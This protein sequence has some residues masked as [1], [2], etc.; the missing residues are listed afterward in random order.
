MAFKKVDD[1]IKQ[2][3]IGAES[4]T[5]FQALEL[6]NCIED[7]LYFMTTFMKVQH[8]TKGALDFKPYPFQL[9]IIKA[10]HENRFS[11]IL[12]GRQLGKTSCAA[13]FLLWK[14]MFTSDMTILITANKLSQA[15]E[16][17]DRIKYA[18]ENMPN[19]IRAGVK[20]YNKQT[21]EFD[22]GSK[23]VA[24]ATTTDAGRGLSVS[25]LYID[26]FSF[27]LP[28]KAKEFWTSIQPTLSTG[29][30]CIITS[31]PKTDE[32]QFA[33][34]WKGATDNVDE[35]GNERPGKLGKNNFF[36]V[37]APW[38]EHPDRDEEWAKTYRE[39]LGEARFAQEMECVTGDTL[40]NIKELNGNIIN[41]SLEEHKNR[42]KNENIR[43]IENLEGLQILTPTG[44]QSFAG[45]GIMGQHEIYEVEFS[46]GKTI[47]CS[48]KHRFVDKF[49][50]EIKTLDLV[51]DDEIKS[52]NGLVTVISVNK[53]S[54]IQDTY[55]PIE[56]G[57]GHVYFSDGIASKNCSF[58]TD[59][60]TLINPLTLVRLSGIQPVYYTGTVR[61]Y[62]EPE[63]NKTYL[64][65]LDPSLGT[66][67]DYAGLQV[68]QLPEMIQVAEWKHNG[69]APKGQIRVLMATLIYLESVLKENPLQ[70]GEPEIFWSVENNSI[71]EAV[72]QIIED[73]GEE[74]FPGQFITEKK[75]KGQ[76]R[77]FRKGMN[78][79]H[80]NKLSA[81]A[82]LKS[83]VESD[84]MKINSSNLIKELKSFVAKENTFSAKPGEHDDLVS[85]LLLIVRM[86]DVAI[87]WSQN[88]GDLKEYID[89]DELCDS[90]PMPM[91]V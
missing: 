49:D 68:F 80:K 8:P 76:V 12:T 74:R 34:I 85:A 11:I 69:T 10:F 84:R 32:D 40:V 52:E 65:A 2:P 21:V 14:V 33:Q 88:V 13:G 23:I 53:T 61:W 6:M 4:Y 19:Y 71:G 15:I 82:R 5:E 46:N 73:T 57:N 3:N 62:T 50:Y 22:N 83:L 25:L 81:C 54:E 41:I 59:D 20:V 70:R 64:V 27:V 26:E 24:R 90:E 86:L 60:E 89:D 29:G 67:N 31:T 39:Q 55:S 63:A 7:P 17:V 91:V 42:L 79:T 66:S 16:I 28:S 58:V 48:E 87:G 35:Y 1:K 30:G 38:W 44:W 9:R 56:V 45:V 78:T 51:I 36:A 75:R 18:Y 77:R 43:N 72:L 37:K 47:K